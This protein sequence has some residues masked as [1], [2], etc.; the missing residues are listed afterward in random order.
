MGSPRMTNGVAISRQ[1]I[2]NIDGMIKF[3]VS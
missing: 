2:K 3:N 1:G